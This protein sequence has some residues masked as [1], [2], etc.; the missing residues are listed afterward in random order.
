MIEAVTK[1]IALIVY[2]GSTGNDI[3]GITV[4]VYSNSAELRVGLR[5]RAQGPI[6]TFL[7]TYITKILGYGTQIYFMVLSFDV[8]CSM[9][10]PKIM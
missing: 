6:F 9:V 4:Y 10:I 5:P 3:V 8:A 2:R 1:E 7:I